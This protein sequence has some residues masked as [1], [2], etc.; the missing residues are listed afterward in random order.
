MKI[1][2]KNFCYLAC[3]IIAFK[4]LRTLDTVKKDIQSN[5]DIKEKIII[6]LKDKFPNLIVQNDDIRKKYFKY[7]DSKSIL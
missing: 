3:S 4:Y 1:L 6:L 5:D 7:S 2:L